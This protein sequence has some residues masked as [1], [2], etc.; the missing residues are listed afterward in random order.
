MKTRTLEKVDRRRKLWF[1]YCGYE[2]GFCMSNNGCSGTF[3]LGHVTCRH[4]RRNHPV[5]G[6]PP[7]G[8]NGYH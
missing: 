6:Y 1:P 5:R 8:T 2:H 3:I 4:F 7:E